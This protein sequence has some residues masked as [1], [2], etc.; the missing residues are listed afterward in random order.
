[1]KNAIILILFTG[2]I[3]FL[4]WWISDEPLNP[5]AQHWIDEPVEESAAYNL[6]LGM[7]SEP[8]QS[9]EKEGKRLFLA[10]QQDPAVST[11]N[12]F[13][14]LKSQDLLC[15][16][17]SYA[18]LKAQRDHVNAIPEILQ[19]Y[20]ALIDRYRQLIAME[21]YVDNTPLNLTADF[22]RYDLLV[23]ASRLSSLQLITQPDISRALATEIQQ[24]R[25][26]L[27][28]DHNLISKLVTARILTEKLQLAALLV[29][30]GTPISLTDYQLS[31]EEKSLA[32]ALRYEFLFRAHFLIDEQYK[33][34]AAESTLW[35]RLALF[36]GT[37]THI[38][39]NRDLASTL[40]YADLSE[41]PAAI[42]VDDHYVMPDPTTSQAIRNPFGNYLLELASPDMKP[43][44]L[45]MA[46][47]DAKLQLLGWLRHPSE[48]FPNPW[49]E[50]D[51]ISID[52]VKHR[53]CF[54]T[55]Q[56][57]DQ[58]HSCLPWLPST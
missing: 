15:D 32:T 25:H 44:L 45:R 36:L 56:N 16:Y 4:G 52:K 33:E 35:E 10:R 14:R 54:P 58:H 13:D 28:Q 37:R 31:T 3:F 27:T 46:H 30:E 40:H 49:P 47:L 19:E 20:G 21:R 43:Y 38:T 8:D 26:F 5:V 41:N 17:A 34:G 42:I 50:A 23:D 12:H 24:I 57:S 1:M 6:L 9:A 51:P 2:L 55:A 22:P 39:L 7:G 53:I 18:C 11:P 48:T 29:Q